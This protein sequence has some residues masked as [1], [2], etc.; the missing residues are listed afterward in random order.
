MSKPKLGSDEGFTR[1]R[2]STCGACGCGKA[3]TIGGW[4]FGRADGAVRCVSCQLKARFATMTISEQ[5]EYLERIV[6]F[7]SDDDDAT[8]EPA[9]TPVPGLGQPGRT[10]EPDAP[11]EGDPS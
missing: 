4:Q 5:E 8:R 11:P 10:P 2:A 6:A 3:L 9:A 1:Q 7:C